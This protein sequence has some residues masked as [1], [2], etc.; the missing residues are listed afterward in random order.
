MKQLLSTTGQV[1][2]IVALSPQIRVRD[3]ATQLNITERTVI[4]ALSQLVRSQ[5]I[6]AH[7]N[8]RRNYY[9][10]KPNVLIEVGS[11]Q[12]QVEDLLRITKRGPTTQ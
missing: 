11:H 9:E 12:I 7:R 3:I 1:L 6:T 10:Y 2:L 4:V 8:G 5:L